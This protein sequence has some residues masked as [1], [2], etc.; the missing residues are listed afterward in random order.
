MATRGN[1]TRNRSFEKV[2]V[3]EI[4]G[5]IIY[6]ESLVNRSNKLGLLHNFLNIVKLLN[7][8]IHCKPAY[9]LPMI[10]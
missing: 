4:A 1:L 6:Y 3:S 5:F 10:A 7:H 9:I 2:S 8:I